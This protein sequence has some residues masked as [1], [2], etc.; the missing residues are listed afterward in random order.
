MSKTE[1]NICP[2]GVIQPLEFDPVPLARK[3]LADVRRAQPDANIL[4]EVI[5]K[6][7]E[8]I[9]SFGENRM[10]LTQNSQA[11]IVNGAHKIASAKE[12]IL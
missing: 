12:R 3:A 9:N 8:I 4:P 2:S 5:T 6:T 7:I 10:L 11:L 1:I